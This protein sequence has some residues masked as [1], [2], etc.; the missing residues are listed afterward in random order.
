MNQVWTVNFFHKQKSPNYIAVSAKI[1]CR[2]SRGGCSPSK[3]SHCQQGT[4]PMKSFIIFFSPQP[5]SG[6]VQRS[7]DSH[8]KSH[9]VFLAYGSSIPNDLYLSQCHDSCRVLHFTP[10]LQAKVKNEMVTRCGQDFVSH[11]C[12]VISQAAREEF[13]EHAVPHWELEQADS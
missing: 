11:W 7:Q 6:L 3:F 10:H 1:L 13:P 4:Q 8:T 5:V 9:S 12:Y 2:P